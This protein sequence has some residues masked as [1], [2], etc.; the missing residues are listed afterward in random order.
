MKNETPE[1]FCP[2]QLCIRSALFIF[3]DSQSQKNCFLLCNRVTFI[4]LLRE[5][6]YISSGFIE[7][8]SNVF[9]SFSNISV[10]FV[11]IIVSVLCL[12]FRIQFCFLTLFQYLCWIFLLTQNIILSK[13]ILGLA[14]VW[15]RPQASRSKRMHFGADI[16]K[17]ESSSKFNHLH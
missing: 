11:F 1:I 2:S 6:Y 9:K 12:L 4:V 8:R 16:I 17:D 7:Y 13:T 10:L 3:Q 15:S 14:G 5:G